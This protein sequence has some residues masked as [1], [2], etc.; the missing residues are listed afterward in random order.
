MTK[1]GSASRLSNHARVS[2]LRVSLLPL[3]SFR[4]LPRCAR[5]ASLRE[6]SVPFEVPSESADRPALAQLNVAD[7]TTVRLAATAV[8]G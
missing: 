2:S 8:D 4:G 5:S 6:R 1:D 7:L 3:A